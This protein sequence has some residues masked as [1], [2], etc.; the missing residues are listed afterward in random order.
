MN[1]KYTHYSV[2]NALLD[3]VKDMVLEQIKEELHEAKYFTILADESKDTC[4]KEQVVVAVCYCFNSAI[5]EE[6]IGLAQ[7][8]SLDADGL[9]DIIIHQLRRVH[10]N[11]KNCVGQGYDGT[12][13]VFGHL[14]GVQKKIPEKTGP[15]M[16]YYVH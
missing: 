7:A 12:S 11:T 5:H 16:A 8:Q 10:A 6:F 9:S 2:Q 1:A 15:E 13:V 14:N 3:F 4:K